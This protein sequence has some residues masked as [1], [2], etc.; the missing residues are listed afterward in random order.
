V[1]WSKVSAGVPVARSTDV[2]RSR[3]LVGSS[4]P[5]YSFVDELFGGLGLVFVLGGVFFFFVF[6]FVL[7]L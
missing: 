3:R 2:D 5:S 6:F 1:R 4:S 7:G